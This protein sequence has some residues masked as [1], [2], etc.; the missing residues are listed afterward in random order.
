MSQLQEFLDVLETSEKKT[1]KV[2]VSSRKTVSL[3][4]LSFKQ[5]KS[6]VTTSLNGVGGIMSFIKN[7][8]D[9][10]IQNTGEQGLKIYDKVPIIL[11]MRKEL[12]PKKISVGDIDIDINDLISNFKKFEVSEDVVVEG[13][14]YS[15]KLIIP[16]LEQENRLLSTCVEDLKKIDSDNIGKNVSLILSYEVPKFMETISFGS[17]F[18]KMDE[19][20][21]S[22][23]TKIMDNLPA[24]VTNKITDYILKVREYDDTLLTVNGVT[25]DINSNFFE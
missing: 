6:L 25:I 17:T 14:G 20:S 15:I 2:N 18:I 23:R 21:I 16:T 4:P 9:V 10:I 5:Q 8:N 11:A 13:V 1:V 22:D 19:I 7:L 12:S 24:N 3:K